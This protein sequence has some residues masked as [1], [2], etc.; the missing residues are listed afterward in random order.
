MFFRRL[1]ICLGL[2]IFPQFVTPLLFSQQQAADSKPA[3]TEA[4]SSAVRFESPDVAT[5]APVF[6]QI[7]VA[8]IR[9]APSRN[10]DD[11]KK[12][13]TEL[14]GSADDIQD[15]V[16][17]MR[18]SGLSVKDQ[19]RLTRLA[20]H[21]AGIS[22]G[23]LTP[24]ATGASTTRGGQPILNYQDVSTGLQV[25]ATPT[26]QNEQIVIKLEISRNYL[27]DSRQPSEE[28]ESE[29]VPQDNATLTSN[30]TVAMKD[31]QSV[32]YGITESASGRFWIV[33]VTARQLP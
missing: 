33:V 31:N 19:V 20:G 30:T 17:Q 10:T 2:L 1:A 11:R 32:A 21:S 6:V 12:S 13:L 7:D 3:S 9:T 23:A 5:S 24:R 16:E 27:D 28:K 25:N 4:A 8:L 29:F 26:I 18:L 15:R 22:S 14:I